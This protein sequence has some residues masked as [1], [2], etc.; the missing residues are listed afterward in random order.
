V[1]RDKT[2]ERLVYQGS[3]IRIYN[4][5]PRWYSVEVGRDWIADFRAR[6]RTS[7]DDWW[8]GLPTL[9][10]LW[11]VFACNNGD[12]IDL[13]CNDRP[14]RYTSQN[15]LITLELLISDMRYAATKSY[16]THQPPKG[17]CR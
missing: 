3:S 9:R 6:H 1:A 13:E 17:C 7:D 2:I 5:G 4:L 14:C 10:S 15:S 16:R 12:V 8:K 11:V